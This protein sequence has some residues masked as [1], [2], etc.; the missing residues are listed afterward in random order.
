MATDTAYDAQDQGPALLVVIWTLTG[1]T[2][3]MVAVRLFIRTKIIRNLG[4]DDWLI[5]FS[6]VC[7]RPPASA[8]AR[9]HINPHSPMQ[10]LG[11]VNVALTTL[12]V[13]HGFGKHSSTIGPVATEKANFII[14][15]GWIF[16][17][18]SFA[19]PKLGI[20]ALLTRILNPSPRV[21][22][23]IWGLTGFVGVVAVVN[24][25]VFFTSCNPPEALWHP[26]AGMTC[27][28]TEVIIGYATFNG[29]TSAF[30]D[31][32][33]AV[34]PSM[35]LWRLQMSLRKKIA[36]CLALGVGTVVE[37]DLVVLG[38]CIPTLQPLLELILGKRS[39][40]SSSHPPS[41]PYDSTNSR[42]KRSQL[43]RRTQDTLQL[44]SEENILPVDLKKESSGMKIQRTDHVVVEYEM[45][46][47]SPE[48]HRDNGAIPSGMR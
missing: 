20:A 43:S 36:L 47:L 19:V 31:L 5:A 48:Q 45:H 8:I 39:L 18:L 28:S 13:H 42:P 35:V 30:T 16:G 14:D 40:G 22:W 9:D 11:L 26:T 34:Y 37:A 4:L 7:T 46:R 25:L 33:L 2:T 24:I 27:R 38:S 10:V 15:I 12:A 6:M 1:I 23:M 21:W 32:A 44:G 3:V 17:I 29:A 41:Y